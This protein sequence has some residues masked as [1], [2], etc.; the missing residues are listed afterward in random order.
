ML[1]WQNG[2]WNNNLDFA[3]SKNISECKIKYGSKSQWII[4][5][6]G[7]GNNQI[8]GATVTVAV[9]VAQAMAK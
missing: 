9:S 5:L 1:I 4:N 2:Y 7:M 6:N 8:V 3:K